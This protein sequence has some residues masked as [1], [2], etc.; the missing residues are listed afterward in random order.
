M[1]Q[2]IY[3][4]AFNNKYFLGPSHENLFLYVNSQKL[5][6]VGGGGGGPAAPPPPPA[7]LS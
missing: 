3:M 6:F 7:R 4:T 1:V 2:K 5:P